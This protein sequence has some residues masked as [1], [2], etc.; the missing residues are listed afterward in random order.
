M[1]QNP[2]LDLRSD[3]KSFDM[4]RYADV[5]LN[6]KSRGHF[7]CPSNY[8]TQDFSLFL[9]HDV[10]ISLNN[11][12]EMAKIESA[13]KIHAHYYFLTD[14][15]SYNIYSNRFKEGVAQIR[16]YGHCVGLHFERI[17]SEIPE[18]IEFQNQANRLSQACSFEVK[19]FSPHNPGSLTAAKKSNVTSTYINAYSFINADWGYLSD[20]NGK[21]QEEYLNDFVYV[22]KF[23]SYQ[24]LIH[25]EWWCM[26]DMQ[27]LDRAI[28]A[29]TEEYL[30]NLAKF[31]D[32]H[33]DSNRYSESELLQL[34][35]KIS[36]IVKTINRLLGR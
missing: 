12:I 29:Y 7:V 23:K 9:R 27:I 11:A 15:S 3:L 32:F 1:V 2:P 18:Y 4:R 6:L 36:L 10:D 21:W 28:S 22:R 33:L 14:S 8:L 24:V 19:H 20:S 31:R 16:S 17:N 35:E 30:D 13:V 5:L 34:T 25:P 26:N